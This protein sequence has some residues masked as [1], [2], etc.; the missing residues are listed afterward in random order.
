MRIARVIY[1]LLTNND[2]KHNKFNEPPVAVSNK[3][4][5]ATTIWQKDQTKK[6]F[7]KIKK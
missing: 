1:G 2:Q 7:K 4:R 6:F 5:Y 3:W